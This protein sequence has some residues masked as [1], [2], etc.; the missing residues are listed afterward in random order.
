M[1][2]TAPAALTDRVSS[3]LNRFSLSNLKADRPL[4]VGLPK[5][6]TQTTR[7]LIAIGLALLVWM[8]SSQ[9]ATAVIIV[10]ALW[11]VVDSWQRR[12]R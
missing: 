10:F 11:L 7:W 6:W 9:L 5:D 12:R 1:R 8:F 3:A 2:S 4:Q